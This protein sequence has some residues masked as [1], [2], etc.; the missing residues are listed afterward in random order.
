ML[1]SAPIPAVLP[2]VTWEDRAL[3]DGG[4]ANNTP[5][6]HAVELGAQQIYVLPTGHACALEKPPRGALTMALNARSLLTQQRLINDIEKHEHDARLIVLPPPC[7]LAIA[8]TDFDHAELLIQR[9]HAD[10]CE[11]LDA[12]GADRPPIRMRVHCHHPPAR[13]RLAAKDAA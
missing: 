10:A 1:A 7:P 6:S 3:M 12:G 2:P 4:V 8:P 13:S 9:G 5:V 11:F